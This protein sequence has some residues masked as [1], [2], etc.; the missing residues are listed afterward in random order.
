M[1]KEVG[2]F[3]EKYAIG[4]Y[5]IKKKIALKTNVLLIP[6]S[7]SYWR[8]R[9]G[10]ASQNV[11]KNYRS[12]LEQFEIDYNILNDIHL[13]LNK[14]EHKLA[15]EKLIRRTVIQIFRNTL[16]KGKITDF[17]SLKKK[18]KLNYLDF[19]KMFKKTRISTKLGRSGEDPF[20]T[21]YNFL[22]T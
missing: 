3:S 21:N 14:E 13:P 12:L 17:T 15:H 19:F 18:T 11:G 10:Q 5:Y 9:A 8:V 22:K 7:I 6:I 16:L 4:D 20:F 2:G 1:L